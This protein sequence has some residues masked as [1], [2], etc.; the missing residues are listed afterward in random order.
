V[1]LRADG[2]Q[3]VIEVGDNGPG[4]APSERA[5]V[6]ERFVRLHPS[7]ATGSGL[8]LA[9]VREIASQHGASLSLLDT[10]GGGLTVRVVLPLAKPNH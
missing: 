2:G 9:I 8:G 6:L 1:S 5:Q 4:I 3:A 10:P 7:G